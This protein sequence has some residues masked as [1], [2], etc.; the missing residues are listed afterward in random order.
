[1]IEKIYKWYMRNKTV[2]KIKV[3]INSFINSIVNNPLSNWLKE[4]LN[5]G[6][7]YPVYLYSKETGEYFLDLNKQVLDGKTYTSISTVPY[8]EKAKNLQDKNKMQQILLRKKVNKLTGRQFHFKRILTISNL[9][10]KQ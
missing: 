3:I 2:S 10:K 8:L 1:M 6:L 7:D 5:I 9:D 4:T